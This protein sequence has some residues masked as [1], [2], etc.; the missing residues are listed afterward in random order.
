[1]QARIV[2]RL[3]SCPDEQ[4]ELKKRLAERLEEKRAVINE[5]V[6][7]ETEI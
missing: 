6:Q 7:K 5:L 2:E 1:M 3:F 4:I